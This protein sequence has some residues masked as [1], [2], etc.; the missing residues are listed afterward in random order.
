MNFGDLSY[1]GVGLKLTTF[2]ICSVPALYCGCETAE[3]GSA[4]SLSFCPASWEEEGRIT[5]KS[6]F[7]SLQCVTST[8]FFFLSI[9]VFC[10]CF[11]HY[12]FLITTKEQAFCR[13]AEASQCLL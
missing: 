13:L 5:E 8:C 10:Q 11:K 3:T 9:N 12:S 1:P 2:S 4:K 6:Y 7:P